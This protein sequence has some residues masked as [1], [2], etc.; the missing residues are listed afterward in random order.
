MSVIAA[1]NR[2][3]C[4]VSFAIAI[5]ITCSACGSKKTSAPGKVAAK[6]VIGTS[7]QCWPSSGCVAHQ[8]CL[9]D[10]S[11]LT[12]C[13]CDTGGNAG[14]GDT[15]AD[16][17]MLGGDDAGAHDAGA[18]DTGAHDAMVPAG[19]AGTHGPEICDNG[20]D[21]DGNGKVDCADSACTTHSCVAAAP[22]GFAGPVELFVGTGSLPSCAGGFTQT[23][24]N[25]GTAAVFDPATCSSCQCSAPAACASFLDF[26]VSGAGNCGTGSTCTSTVSASCAQLGSSCLVGQSTVSLEARP[27]GAS[28]SCTA[29]TENATKNAPSWAVQ[30]LACAPPHVGQGCKQAEVCAPAR[31]A[32]PFQ[33]TLCVYKSGDVACPAA[34]YTD[35][36]VY[37]TKLDDTRSCSACTCSDTGTC[38]YAWNV[39]DTTDTSCASAPVVTLAENQCAQVNPS[40]DKLRVGVGIT[41]APGCSSGGGQPQGA[42]SA[43]GAVT[44]CCEP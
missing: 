14:T 11:G 4:A 5:A 23:A 26:R 37:Y 32:S 28:S 38:S 3:G 10:G 6:C 9:P 43:S 2:I 16:G 30:A 29:G 13:T 18:H 8:M 19:D 39:Y 22:S 25:G 24:L 33:S 31:L 34:T 40:S 27:I 12:N 1:W 7:Y 17:G 35:K 42:V 21:D 36:R 20:K 44:V 41:G 15:A